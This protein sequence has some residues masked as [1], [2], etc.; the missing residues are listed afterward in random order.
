[1]ALAVVQLF[2][3]GSVIQR[4]NASLIPSFLLKDIENLPMYCKMFG[5]RLI[6][7]SLIALVCAGMSFTSAE[8]DSRP[9]II[10][11]GG[12]VLVLILMG[13]DHRKYSNK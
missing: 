8:F 1:M 11:G 7:L 2:G 3:V 10:F 4:G 9:M 13:L 6:L 5:N 12:I